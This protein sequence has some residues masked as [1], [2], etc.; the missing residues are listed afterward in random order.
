[1]LKNFLVGLMCFTLF[2][3][4]WA[5]NSKPLYNAYSN[6]YEIASKS[7][8]SNAKFIYGN[9]L[10][11]ILSFHRTGEVVTIYDHTSLEDLLTAFNAKVIFTEQTV[12]GT[13]VYAFSS[14][15]A[16]RKEINRKI[17]NI[18]IFFNEQKIMIGSPIIYGG[19]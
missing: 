7:T 6:S 12:Y 14:K 10:D 15:I 3:S 19:Y 13:S 4:L 2:I 16:Y 11:Y 18:Q 5:T 17:I 1:M 8:S 9:N